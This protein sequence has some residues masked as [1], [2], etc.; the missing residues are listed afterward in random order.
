MQKVFELLGDKPEAAKTNADTVMRMET[1]LAKSSVDARGAAQS[2]QL[3]KQDEDGRPRSLAPNFD[4]ADVLPRGEI[5]AV[6]DRECGC[7]QSSIKQVN[8]LLAS[9]PLDNWKTYF[10]F[11]VADSYSAVSFAAF[12][13]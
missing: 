7:R 2:L 12:C 3:E 8:D 13:G 9:E 5:S 1:A 6:R 10:R 11:H 4:W